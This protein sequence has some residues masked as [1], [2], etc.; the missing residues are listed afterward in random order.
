MFIN[1]LI[2]FPIA[3][4]AAL[5]T[6]YEAVRADVFV[7]SGMRRTEETLAV[8]FGTRPHQQDSRLREM[9]FGIFDYETY[10]V[11]SFCCGYG[12]DFDWYVFTWCNT[13]ILY[14]ISWRIHIND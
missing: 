7:T 4:L 8:L 3:Q 6:R 2:P 9:D 13:D 5:R 11:G 14:W 12:T 10:M 1:G